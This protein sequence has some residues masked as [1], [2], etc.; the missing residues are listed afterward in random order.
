MKKNTGSRIMVYIV[1]MVTLLCGISIPALLRHPSVQDQRTAMRL[2]EL[3]NMEADKLLSRKNDSNS[4]EEVIQNLTPAEQLSQKAIEDLT[5]Q[6]FSQ[7]QIK[8]AQD[9]VER[10]RLQLQD[11]LLVPTVQVSGHMDDEK[12]EFQQLAEKIS[13]ETA[14]YFLLHFDDQQENFSNAM[15]EYLCCLQLDLEIQMY[16]E[17]R[18]KYEQE[19]IE[20]QIR[21]QK[22]LITVFD[23]ESKLLE[24]LRGEQAEIGQPTPQIGDHDVPINPSNKKAVTVPNPTEEIMKEINDIRSKSLEN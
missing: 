6:G 21:R 15:D 7:E 16:F 12:E 20:G 22:K 9:Y 10:I 19:K 11:I 8:G 5:A 2:A 3:N 13:V 14:V 17:D 23:I 18:E 4:W 24:K 1:L